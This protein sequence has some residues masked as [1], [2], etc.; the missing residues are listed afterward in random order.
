MSAMIPPASNGARSQKLL[1]NTG[2][3]NILAYPARS[4][5]AVIIN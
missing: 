1:V 5:I 3:D 2:G 4:P